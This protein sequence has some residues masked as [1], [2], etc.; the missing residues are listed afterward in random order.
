MRGMEHDKNDNRT[1]AVR[2]T[3]QGRKAAR[4]A[5]PLWTPRQGNRAPWICI[6]LAVDGI[7]Q[8]NVVGARATELRSAGRRRPGGV[9][10]GVAEQGLDLPRQAR[11]PHHLRLA[12]RLAWL[13]GGMVAVAGLVG[14]W[15]W[16]DPP[17][18]PALAQPAISAPGGV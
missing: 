15:L 4:G 8:L 17:P 1:Q 3:A 14:A 11:E 13:G 12:G 9:P 18:P 10:H 6:P 7:I 16:P 5:P 2:G